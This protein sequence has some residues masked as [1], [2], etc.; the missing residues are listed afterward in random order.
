[1]PAPQWPTGKRVVVRAFGESPMEA[2]DEHMVLEPQPAPDPSD[3]GPKDLLIGVRSCA[4]GWVDLIMSSGQYQH[5]AKPP[6]VPGL[7]YA[8]EV[9]A[10]GPEVRGRAVGDA[11]LVDGLIAGPRSLG[12]YQRWGGFASYAV[13][14]EEAALPLPPGWSFAQGCNLLGNYETA[15]HCLITRGQLR[16][17]E[18]VLINGASGATGLAAVHIAK[19]VGATV[20]ATGRSPAKLEAVAAQGADHVLPC[21]GE[22]DQGLDT[23]RDRVRAIVKGGVDV[24][25]DG[26][27]G[28]LTV[29]SMRAASFG[30]RYLIVGWAATPDVAR[31]KG[32]RG[33]PRVNVVPT[34]LILMKSLDLLGCPTAIATHRDPSIR[35]PR[36]DQILAWVREGRLTPH[37]DRHFAFDDMATVREAM[38]A[39]WNSESVG[40]I[41]LDQPSPIS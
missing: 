41:V 37:V 3:L 24:V 5:M 30:A 38:R 14:P 2:L 22:G 8:G 33:A 10:V 12:P 25:Y 27:G 29:P 19:I 35:K 7:E 23:L 34:N 20:L 28:P 11:V 36:L 26:V 6:Y 13:A 17:G 15:Y 21:G 39:K 31:G 9:L 16:A 32:K 18:T 40:G 1:M 4:V